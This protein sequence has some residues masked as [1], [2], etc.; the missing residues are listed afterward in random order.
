MCVTT[1]H[2]QRTDA[3]WRSIRQ[4]WVFMIPPTVS[5]QYSYLR[6]FFMYMS[7][8]FFTSRNISH[9]V[10]VIVCV[11][12]LLHERWVCLSCHFAHSNLFLVVVHSV[13]LFPITWRWPRCCADLAITVID[14]VD[15]WLFG[16]SAVYVVF[17]AWTFPPYLVEVVTTPAIIVTSFFVIISNDGSMNL[18]GGGVH[19][20]GFW[21]E[22]TFGTVVEA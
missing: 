2:V 17:P 4:M 22:L 20:R 11:G 8:V 14:D 10:F 13:S 1:E 16:L 15:N 19:C 9:A 12:C 7:L 3:V 21:Q 18:S 5:W 6:I